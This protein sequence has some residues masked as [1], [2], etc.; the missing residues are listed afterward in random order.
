M[1]NQK[2]AVQSG[3]WLLYRYNPELAA[4]GEVPLHIDS[5]APK[6]PVTEYLKL[7]NRFRMLGKSNPEEAKR[8]FDLAQE[9]I[10]RRWQLY[11]R[12]SS[13]GSTANRE[14]A[15]TSQPTATPQPGTANTVP[16]ESASQARQ[17]STINR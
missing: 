6:L 11:Q 4:K 13:N 5:A 17:R 9:N 3:Q 16:T 10:Q 1:Q 8:L 2:A 14:R 7:E 15:A 12:L